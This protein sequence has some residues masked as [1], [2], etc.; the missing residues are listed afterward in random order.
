[1]TKR[2]SAKWLVKAVLTGEW[3][4]DSALE[5]HLH[6]NYRGPLAILPDSKLNRALCYANMKWWDR[7]LELQDGPMTVAEIIR[8]FRLTPFLPL[9]ARQETAAVHLGDLVKYDGQDYRVIGRREVW[10]F[11]A[12]RYGNF[13]VFIEKEDGT[14]YTVVEEFEFDNDD[15]EETP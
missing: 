4:C 2:R 5:E 15:K 1:M 11:A 7:E 12:P 6:E 14:G 9:Y 13:E 8:E 3:T 10:P